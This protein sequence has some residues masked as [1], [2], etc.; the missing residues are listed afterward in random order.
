MF[1]KLIYILTA[2][3]IINSTYGATT[4]VLCANRNKQWRWLISDSEY[5]SVSGEWKIMAFKGFVYQYFE[6]DNF[7]LTEILQEKCKDRFGDSYI[8]A[9]PAKSFADQ[10][11]VFGIKGSIL[12]SG[13]YKYCLNHYSCYFRENKSNLI[14]NSFNFENLN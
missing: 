9:Q 5:V 8:Y 1:K 7:A 6:L 14:L 13:F 11:H 12:S 2:G 4:S 10:W 3:F